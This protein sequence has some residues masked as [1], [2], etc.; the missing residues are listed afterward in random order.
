MR[1]DG[2]IEA[3]DSPYFE[4][5]SSLDEKWLGLMETEIQFVNLATDLSEVIW[6]LVPIL[7]WMFAIYQGMDILSMERL[8]DPQ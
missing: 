7:I 5:I 6:P 4:T 3:T 2:T 1:N 8:Q